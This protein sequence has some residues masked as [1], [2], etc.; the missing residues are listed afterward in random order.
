M[1]GSFLI[2]GCESFIGRAFLEHMHIHGSRVVG[3]SRRPGSSYIVLN[4]GTNESTFTIPKSVTIAYVFAGMTN[5]KICKDDPTRTRFIN[6]D[7]TKKLIDRLLGQGVYVVFLS[8]DVAANSTSVYGRQKLE[9]ERYLEDK[10]ATIVR[11]GKVITSD[12]GLLAGWVRELE[13]RRPIHPFKDYWFSPISMGQ[14]LTILGNQTLL[15]THSK[16]LVSAM[17]PLSYYHAIDFI[18]KNRRLNRSLIIPQVKNT[19][20]GKC[21]SLDSSFKACRNSAWDTL[22][23]LFGVSRN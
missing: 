8:S 22:T 20:E 16:I 11:L 2:I 7:C 4:L 12:T 19:L 23:E 18:A 9:V 6:V 13:A 17:E 14:V 15:H 5:L 21:F 1:H 10:D 3:T